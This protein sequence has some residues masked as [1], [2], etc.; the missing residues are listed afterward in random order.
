M[1]ERS[2]KFTTIS[3]TPIN[4]LYKPEDISHLVYQKDLNDPAHFP[5][6]RGIH[7]TMYRGRLW[8]MRLFSGFGKPEETNKRYK[9]LLE[10]GQ[11]GLSVAFDFPTLM[12]Y[13][14]D[15]ERAAGE[16]GKCGVNISTLAD[17]EVL[18]D[19]I[20]LDQVTTS[21]TINGPAAVLLAMY[22]VVAEK[23]G[24]SWD[25]VGG[26]VQNDVLKEF[27]AQNSYAFPPDPS[28][29]VVVDMIEF[30]T[31]EVP[32][33]NTVSISGYHI[34]EAGSTAVQELAFTLADGIA[35]VQ[36]C[37][38]RGMKVD[39][40]ASRLSFF[41]DAHND[42]FEEIAKFRAARRMWAKIMKERFHAKNEKSMMLR[43]HT[44]TAGASLTAQ[45]PYNNVVRTSIQALAA[46]LGG[47]QSL[48]TNAWDETFALPTELAAM[49]AL[50][51][52]QIIA[53]E[54]GVTNTVDPLA[55]SY[56]IESLTNQM[57]KEAA[58]TIKKIDEMGGMVQAVKA[59]YPQREIADASYRYQKQVD[60][61]EKII[62]GVN[63]FKLNKEPP[64]ETLK[65]ADEIRDHQ[66]KKIAQVKKRRDAQKV[67]DT[68]AKLKKAAQTNQN[69][70]VPLCDSVRAYCTLNEMMETLKS[71]FGEYH[72][73]GIF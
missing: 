45:Q 38:E 53:H 46:V 55:G 26:T 3:S 10:H 57:E 13:D 41:F 19:H 5:Y 40:F 1:K 9:F 32:K 7:E 4:R 18:F 63:E 33:W 34:R 37:V 29:R 12:G 62:V 43:F 39:D 24:V 49:T 70:M 60:S 25:K 22:L 65:I 66:A 58:A 27:T 11:T 14:A 61:K 15:Q 73:P 2:E 28:M 23:Q 50:R 44:Q 35:Y 72:D 20:P 69:I 67:S 36:A 54:S 30:C 47:T 31:K 52:Q 8:T 68:L 51:T 56:F 71:V 42:F 6:T 48:H 59:G 17:M 64:I 21:M 16:V